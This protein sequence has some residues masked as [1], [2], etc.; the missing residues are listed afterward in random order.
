MSRDDWREL[1]DALDESP[2]ST[3]L[4]VIAVFVILWIIE[5]LRQP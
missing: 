3:I 4:I 5:M 2:V 1:I